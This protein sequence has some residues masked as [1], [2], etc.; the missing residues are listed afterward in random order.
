VYLCCTYLHSDLFFITFITVLSAKCDMQQ[1]E[2]HKKR[3]PSERSLK[4]ALCYSG[5]SENAAGKIWKW[6]NP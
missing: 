5:Y 3:T 4:K 2:K 6:Y 1:E